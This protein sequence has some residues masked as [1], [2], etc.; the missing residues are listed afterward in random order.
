[1]SSTYKYK[2]DKLSL[3]LTLVSAVVLMGFFDPINWPKQI[4]LVCILPLLLYKTRLAYKRSSRS[5]FV[6]NLIKLLAF[7][8]I[9]ICIASIGSTLFQDVPLTRTLW[10]LWGRNN[11]LLTFLGFFIIA[12]SMCI[13]SLQREFTERFF[14]SLEI[15]SVFFVLYGLLQILE[16]DPIKWSKQGEVFS[17]FGNTNFASAIFYLSASTF[18]VLALF[19]VAPVPLKVLRALFF[20]LT[21]YLLWETRSIQGL[22]ALF[23]TTIFLIYVILNLKQPLL[24]STYFLASSSIGVVI[25]FGTLGLGPL[26]TLI[27]QYTVQ[28]RY[29]YWLVGV[30]I[31]NLSPI[32]GVGV[33]S[34]G[35]HF[36]AQRPES[37]ALKTSIDLTTNNAHNVFIQAYATMGILGLIAVL[38]PAS[39][40]IYFAMRILW[41]NQS[42][43]MDKSIVAIFISLW[44]IAFFSIDNIAIAIWNYA[45][46]GLTFGVYARLKMTAESIQFVEQKKRADIDGMRY[47]ALALSGALFAFSWYASYPDRKV[48]FYLANP[49]NTSDG[50]SVS[51]R[52]QDIVNLSKSPFMMEAQFWNLALELKK[53]NSSNE[54]LELLSIA[55]D[56]FPRDFNILDV[57]ALYREQIG[58]SN[59]AIQFR[60][61]QLEIDKRHPR[62]WLSYA[63]DL[64][65]AGRA[66]D[67]LEAF[68]KVKEFE[69][70]LSEDIKSK[71]AAIEKDFIGSK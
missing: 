68:N 38:T 21:I 28:L 2:I 50:S 14:R 58:L 12:A 47:V 10:G 6:K 34:Y 42:S 56:K 37:L 25:F 53:M 62:V 55:N 19:E 32:W 1:M 66:E 61:K 48:L 64:K 17:F 59:Q 7:S 27:S 15:G 8:V 29:Q 40:G 41:S 43:K 5:K 65:A 13:Y 30:K 35:D 69:K 60:E 26:G 54:L 49:V 44:A 51:A 45:F 16:A 57:S 23:I 52:S 70:F 33:D 3:G 22:A 36:R 39:L 11:G 24:K 71:M 67:A 63:Y 31:G 18:L 4:F 20:I 9:V 46:L